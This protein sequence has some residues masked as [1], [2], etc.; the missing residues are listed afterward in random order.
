MP[1][2]KDLS[3]FGS[4]L[5]MRFTYQYGRLRET[6]EQYLRFFE[7]AGDARRI[8][9]TAVWYLFSKSAA[10]EI[11]SFN[12]EALIIVMLRNPVEMIY[13][14]HS[15]FL[16]NL[17]EDIGNFEAAL[18]AEADRRDGRRIPPRAH[19]PQGLLYRD[20][21]RYAEQ[22]ERY[23]RVFG[24]DR[25]QVI[26]YD[27]FRKNTHREVYKTFEFLGVDPSVSVSMEIM[28]PNKVVRHRRL[29]ALAMAPPGRLESLYHALIPGRFHGR[30]AALARGVSLKYEPRPPLE[31]HVRQRLEQEMTPEIIRLG[32][33]LDRDLSSWLVSR[34]G[35]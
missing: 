9:E 1:A 20:T 5:Q 25:V 2:R 17:N 29:H 30:L 22:L 11:Y 6:S 18:A 34:C 21:A 10:Q 3:F 13:A 24:R 19:F 14:Q 23:F 7:S 26:Y 12:P 16:S 15:Q 33:L 35:N 32:R 8:G 31:A 28:N 4:D 27:D